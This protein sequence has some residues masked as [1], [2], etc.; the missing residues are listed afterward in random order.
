M[1]MNEGVA[2]VAK[3]STALTRTLWICL[4]V[5]CLVAVM[6]VGGCTDET[7]PDDDSDPNGD[8]DDENPPETPPSGRGNEIGLYD[9]LVLEADGWVYYSHFPYEEVSK[10]RIDGSEPSV[11]STD[12][13][14]I[15]FNKVG[16]WLCYVCDAGLVRIRPDGSEREV[17]FAAP[18]PYKLRY[19]TY[20]DGY[21]FVA[22][23]Q[24]GDPDQSILRIPFAE[25]APLEISTDAAAG[26]MC[27]AGNYVYYSTETDGT[28]YRMGL[29]GSSREALGNGFWPIVE[30]DYLYYAH[31]NRVTQ[32]NL[33]TGDERSLTLD[34][35]GNSFQVK[36]E[37]IY[38]THAVD[39]LKL[40]A[41]NWGGGTIAVV[42][43]PVWKA[44]LCDSGIY[45]QQHDDWKLYRVP[46][47]SDTGVMLP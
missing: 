25:G 43:D 15:S 31:E 1:E 33:A 9:A 28:V 38:Y 6:A 7:E 16:E 47:G 40:H 4:L 44:Y 24:E 19:L 32:R 3:K 23:L 26:G 29:D 42:S 45:F 27:V 5:F 22:K 10:A 20:L 39:D 35:Y 36:N 37:E 8:N 14:A 13:G 2:L 17:V 21:Y 11:I 46:P 34:L 30:G 41:A 12:T 18:S